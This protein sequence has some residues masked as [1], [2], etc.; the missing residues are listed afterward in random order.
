MKDVRALEAAIGQKYNCDAVTFGSG[1]ESMLALL[2][3]FGFE[4]GD[5]IIVQGYTCIVMPNAIHAAGMVAVYADIEK[6]TLNFDLEAVKQAITP[7]TRAIVCQN[8]FGIPGNTKALRDLCDAHALLLIEDCAHVLPDELGP[9]ALGKYGDAMLVSFARDKAISGVSGGAMLTRNPTI[10]AALRKEQ[11]AA[12][13]ESLW[14]I[15]ALLQYPLLYAIA[16]PFYAMKIGKAFL[17][18]ASK[19]KLLVPTI[20]KREKE[21]NMPNVLHKMPG[22]CA[23]LALQQLESLRTIND[24]RRQLTNV[25]LAFGKAHNWPL[26]SGIQ[27]GLPLQK[28]PLFSKGADVIRAT[29]KMQNIHLSDGWAGC[30]ICPESA[31]PHDAGYELGSDPSAESAGE[32]ILCLPTHP[33]MTEKQA[34]T[35]ATLLDPLLSK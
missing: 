28:F 15:F 21:G 12:T 33:G 1:R 32:Q 24:H 35:L 10:A 6:D 7:K 3:A 17:L 4:K 30:V 31:D 8:T 19:M 2:R 20:T 18:L 34:L 16:R 27:S 22:A 29:L 13:P 5:E 11:D 9:H 26:L 23:V 25:Y 14:K